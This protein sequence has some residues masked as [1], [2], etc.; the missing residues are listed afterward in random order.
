M[1]YLF[2]S[3]LTLPQEIGL[4]WCRKWTSVTW[5]YAYNRYVAWW[6]QIMSLVASVNHEVLHTPFLDGPALLI[7]LVWHRGIAHYKQ[8]TTLASPH[9]SQ[10]SRCRWNFIQYPQRAGIL[11]LRLWA[12]DS[13]INRCDWILKTHPIP[14]FFSMR[15]HAL[16]GGEKVITSLV[17]VLNLVPFATNIV[18]PHFIV[19]K[20][21]FHSPMD[22]FNYATSELQYLPDLGGCGDVSK[23]SQALSLRYD[24]F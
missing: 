18:S 8:S 10:L 17:L 9:F 20:A 6:L 16:L 11:G 2:D 19:L 14:V 1:L 3:C 22:K 12:S 7:S 23:N 4:M 15:V 13:K 5:L 24:I 21:Y